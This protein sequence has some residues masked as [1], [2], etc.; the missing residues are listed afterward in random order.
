LPLVLLLPL[1][2]V[3]LVALVLRPAFFITSA[4]MSCPP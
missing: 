1:L 4:V 2:V 3:L